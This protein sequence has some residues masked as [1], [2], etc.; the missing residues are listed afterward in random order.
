MT[1]FRNILLKFPYDLI[2]DEI[3]K[4]IMKENSVVCHLE[5]KISQFSKELWYTRDHYVALIKCMRQPNNMKMENR[6]LIKGKRK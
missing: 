5:K 1:T 4:K 3:N 6:Q 2:L